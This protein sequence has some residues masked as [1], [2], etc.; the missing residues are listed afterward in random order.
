MKERRIEHTYN[1]SAEFFWDRLFFDDEYNQ[2]LFIGEL[3]FS[4]YEVVSRDDR[5]A[6]VHRVVRAAPP[7]GDLP[8]ALKR[9][10]SEGLA[11]EERGVLDRKTQ[12]YRLQAVPRS[13]SS[14]V[15]ILGELS[16]RPV[17]ER[18][19]QRVYIAKVEA[20]V[21]GVGGMIEQRVLDD[22][23]KSYNKAATFTNRWIAERFPQG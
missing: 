9:L 23:E 12:I 5:G 20:R 19:C 1:C 13:L 18:S 2:K 15:T 17:S 3:H 14:K 8:S 16:T 4:S 22:L 11:Y 21:L 6:E 10:L 7:L